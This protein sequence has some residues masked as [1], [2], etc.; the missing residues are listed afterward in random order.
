MRG[1]EL[2]L[3]IEQI[4]PLPETNEFMIDAKE[5]AKEKKGKSKK[6]EESN[7]RLLEFWGLLKEE[8]EAKN[9][10]YLD[11]V[12]SKPYYD[13]G[14]SKGKGLFSFC[15]GRNTFRVE[16]YFDNDVDKSKFDGMY[17]YKNELEQTIS[18]IQWQRLDT[19]KASRIKLETT[20]EEKNSFEGN[21]KDKTNWPDVI[22][23]YTE[24][25]LKFYS[26]VYPI[27][28]KVQRKLG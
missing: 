2:F 14:F 21:W 20:I 18:G 8:L 16:L 12:K 1:D 3:Q 27:W 19:K 15:I 11:R 6:V 23:W 25:M 4:I 9:L 10:N 22:D 17:E 28:E 13:I 7:T 24:N 5:K 26:A